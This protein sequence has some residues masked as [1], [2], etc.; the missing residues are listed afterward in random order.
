L[1][2]QQSNFVLFKPQVKAMPHPS[3]KNRCQNRSFWHQSKQF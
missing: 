1:C 2:L 3:S